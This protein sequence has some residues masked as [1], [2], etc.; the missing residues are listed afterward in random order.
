MNLSVST[1]IVHYQTPDLLQAAV[2]SFRHLYA[3]NTL[4]IVDNGS[5][6]N[7]RQV[8]AGLMTLSPSGTRKL[9]IPQN[10]FH[11]PAMDRAMHEIT[12]DLVFFL[13]S[14]TETL[15]GGFLEEM[16][17]LFVAN[18]ELYAAGALVTV[19]KR[20]FYRKD[21]LPIVQTPAMII[22]RSMYLQLPPFEHRGMPT[23][24]NFIA[25]HKRGFGFR[26][27][28]VKSFIRH[29]GRGTAE[30]FGYGLGLSGK[31]EFV[32]ERLIGAFS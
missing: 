8:I 11:G 4:L 30:R 26:D 29:D 19:N 31:I 23:M 17:A 9:M 21:G 13:D 1:V 2:K 3:D 14:D 7:S 16:A 5:D 24:K 27:F 20:G 25:A 12:D 28:P 6:E 10:I 15:K 18:P 22:R 32:I